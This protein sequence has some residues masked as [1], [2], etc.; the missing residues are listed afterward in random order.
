MDSYSLILRYIS[1]RGEE[2]RVL[3]LIERIRVNVYE[4]LLRQILGLNVDI[5]NEREIQV[6]IILEVETIWKMEKSCCVPIEV[7]VFR[8][9]TRKQQ[10]EM[11]F[12]NKIHFDHFFLRYTVIMR[13][14][15]TTP[16][17]ANGMKYEECNTELVYSVVRSSKLRSYGS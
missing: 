2:C 8:L 5:N 7:N 13:P 12:F 4:L 16:H 14:I 10:F 9:S 17:R 6:R 11:I 1:A 15:Y 3:F